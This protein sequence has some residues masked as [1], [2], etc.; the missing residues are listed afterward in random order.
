MILYIRIPKNA[1]TSM[2]DVFGKLNVINNRIDEFYDDVFNSEY[3]EGIYDPSHIGIDMAVDLLGEEILELPSVCVYREPLARIVSAYEFAKKQGLFAY[4]GKDKMN[5]GNF[6]QL[7][8]NNKHRMWHFNS[9]VAWISY[10][11]L[12]IIQDVIRFDHLVEDFEQFKSKHNL[13]I[14]DIEPLNST[15]HKPYE[16]YYNDELRGLVKET[17]KEDYNFFEGELI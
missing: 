7:Y 11:G 15:D 6:C 17:Y 3:C 10:R 12:P 2:Y 4:H 9:Q 14:G 1:S 13:N 16:E 8:C 5:F